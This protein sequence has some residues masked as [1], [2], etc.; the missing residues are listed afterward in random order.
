VLRLLEEE[1]LNQ[2]ELAEVFAP[3]VKREARDVWLSSDERPVATRP[4]V[5]T[6][7]ER[8]AQNGHPIV[9]QDEAAAAKDEHP[10]AGP[11]PLPPSGT[12]DLGPRS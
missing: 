9:P 3:V 4:P 12:P 10:V 5:M 11:V 2:A 8:A 6:P 7:A 1:T